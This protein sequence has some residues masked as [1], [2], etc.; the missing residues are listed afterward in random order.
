MQICIIILM[1]CFPCQ[2][3]ADEGADTDNL[4]LLLPHD[5]QMKGWYLDGEPETAHGEGLFLLINGGAELYLKAGFKNALQAGYAN[6]AG[7]MIN[8]EIYK[9]ASQ[10]SAQMIQ[11]YKIGKNGRPVSIGDEAVLEDYYLNMR[12]GPFQI[13]VSG[14]DTK[15]KTLEAILNFARIIDKNINGFSN[16]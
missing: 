12:I 9:M 6:D 3:P 5:D 8:L 11:K 2:V 4:A 1:F 7:R 10:N 14:F 15:A 16:L 13:T